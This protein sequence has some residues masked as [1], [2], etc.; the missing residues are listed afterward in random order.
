MRMLINDDSTL[1]QDLNEAMIGDPLKRKN[2]L[3]RT[4]PLGGTQEEQRLNPVLWKLIS[5]D[6]TLEDPPKGE[7]TEAGASPANDDTPITPVEPISRQ[8]SIGDENYYTPRS[9]TP[10]Q[11]KYEEDDLFTSTNY[12]LV[13]DL[14]NPHENKRLE[15]PMDRATHSKGIQRMMRS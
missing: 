1:S 14:D 10:T 2:V 4:P 5:E 12:Q 3:A 6:T 13:E 11:D 8:Q 7:N 9:N 15:S